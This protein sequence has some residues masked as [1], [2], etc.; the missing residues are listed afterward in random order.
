MNTLQKRSTTALEARL[1]ILF[2][3]HG[4]LER[5][6]CELNKLRYQV[7]Q[8]ELSA[9][10]ASRQVGA[11]SFSEACPHSEALGRNARQRALRGEVAERGSDG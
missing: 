2:R 10:S 6:F 11:D 8:A 9:P 7:R 5:Q 1:S 3:N 4:D